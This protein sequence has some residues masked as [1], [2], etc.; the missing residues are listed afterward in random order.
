VI[1]ISPMG[2]RTGFYLCEVGQPDLEGVT[3][4]F[5]NARSVLLLV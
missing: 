3:E 5:R 2:C 4:S 1:D